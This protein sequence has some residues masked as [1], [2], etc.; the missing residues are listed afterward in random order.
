MNGPFG[1]ANRPRSGRCRRE[2][3]WPPWFV[4]KSALP[5]TVRLRSAQ[6]SRRAPRKGRKMLK[7]ALETVQ[8][9]TTAEATVASLA[10]HGIDTL[11]ALPGVQND[12]LLDALFK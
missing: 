3:A 2:G 4:K 5:S 12:H 6:S 11:Y 7:Q 1:A 8:P 9:M 10:A